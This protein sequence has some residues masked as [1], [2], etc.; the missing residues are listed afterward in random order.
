MSTLT[1]LPG[2]S[3]G[4]TVRRS[5]DAETSARPVSTSARAM[6][7]VIAAPN[8][9][10]SDRIR[11]PTSSNRPKSIRA[12]TWSDGDSGGIACSGEMPASSD[13][14]TKRKPWARSVSM[15]SGSAAIVWLRS[16][17]ESWSRTT[18]RLHCESD[19]LL[20]VAG[21]LAIRDN[22]LLTMASTPGRCQSSLGEGI[23]TDDKKGRRDVP[24]FQNVEDLRRPARIGTVVEGQCNQSGPV[25]GPGDRKGPGY[26]DEF[27]VREQAIRSITELAFPCG[28]KRREPEDF[29]IAFDVDIGAL[30]DASEPG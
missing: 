26:V 30:R 23:L 17:P 2:R 12:A 27:D 5:F 29:A 9:K 20:P 7:K 13:A 16:P 22:T 24:R 11:N 14:G 1:E 21:A 19:W 8:R 6:P 4:R 18:L 15:I 10:P 28:R 25:S 3:S